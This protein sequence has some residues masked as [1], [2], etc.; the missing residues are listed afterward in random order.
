MLSCDLLC[1]S[2][3]LLTRWALSPALRREKAQSC[4]KLQQKAAWQDQGSS[5]CPAHGTEVPSQLLDPPA[6]LLQR[7]PLFLS[8][9]EL[10][11]PA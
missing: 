3:H 8:I 6:A 4:S 7:S 5:Q 9:D 1:L 11:T 10:E 2:A